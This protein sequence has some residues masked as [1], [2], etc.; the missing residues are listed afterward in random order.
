[1]PLV[2][3]LSW[4]HFSWSLMP[5]DTRHSSLES[6]V[7]TLGST[8]CCV[9]CPVLD[10]KEDVYKWAQSIMAF[11]LFILIIFDQGKCHTLSISLITLIQMREI[12]R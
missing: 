3:S 7:I 1:M 12:T 8:A 9:P 4:P 10:P 2:S 5:S 11:R 6:G